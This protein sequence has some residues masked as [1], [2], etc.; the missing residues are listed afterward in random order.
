MSAEG[1]L[2]PRRRASL[3][4]RLG[5]DLVDVVV[6]GHDHAEAIVRQGAGHYHLRLNRR[7]LK[8]LWIERGGD[9]CTSAYGPHVE[10]PF[11]DI[12]RGIGRL[13]GAAELVGE[14]IGPLDAP[15][16]PVVDVAVLR[17]LHAGLL[18]QADRAIAA[19]SERYGAA[20]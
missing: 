17:G 7:T 10:P 12:D 2:S 5:L 15:T 9:R 19:R 18:R 13:V 20:L 8:H 3:A 11:A 6:L 14:A 1:L 16:D 4:R